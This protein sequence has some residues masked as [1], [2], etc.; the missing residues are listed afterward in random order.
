MA[1][2]LSEAGAALMTASNGPSRNPGQA[3]DNVSRRCVWCSEPV[4]TG[5]Q[6]S[7]VV[8]CSC[9]VRYAWSLFEE[10]DIDVWESIRRRD[11][12]WGVERFGSTLLVTDRHA[13][14]R[15]GE[16]SS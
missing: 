8:E 3:V 7:H 16:V 2:L 11:P 14:T 15:F 4:E 13:A 10:M 12:R 5:W 9:G 1:G 6:R